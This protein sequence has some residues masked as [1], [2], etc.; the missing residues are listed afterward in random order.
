VDAVLIG[1]EELGALRTF[2]SHGPGGDELVL[3]LGPGRHLL[4]EPGGLTR[5]VPF[6]TPLTRYGRDGLYLPAGHL[7]RPR[8]PDDALVVHFGL[9]R[10]SVVVVTEA[11]SCRF[12]V[13]HL[14]PAWS[15]WLGP[16]PTVREGL[17]SAATAVLHQLSE[18]DL[19]APAAGEPTPASFGAPKHEPA[20]RGELVREAVRLEQAGEFALA[21]RQLE[22]AGD[23]YRAARMYELAAGRGRTEDGKSG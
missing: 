16:P 2:L 10:G 6:G 12:S 21:A 4:T 8:P 9:A 18:V 13:D 14:V 19:P 7:L 11:E 3:L 23:F 5:P 22:L 17:S 20:E 1:D 15:L